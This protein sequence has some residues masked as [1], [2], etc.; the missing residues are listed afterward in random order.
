MFRL[1][2]LMKYSTPNRATRNSFAE[3]KNV[4]GGFNFIFLEVKI[5]KSTLHKI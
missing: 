5:I 3:D 1:Q 4:L 2:V